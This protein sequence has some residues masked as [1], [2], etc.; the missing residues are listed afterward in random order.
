MSFIELA[1][2]EEHELVPGFRA[3]FVH[4]ER[5]TCAYWDIDAGAALPEHAHPHE[6]VMTLIEGCFE[7]TLAGE[8][9]SL[10]PGSVVTI[11]GMVRHGG[12]ALTKCVAIDI[13]SPVREDYR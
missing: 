12:K 3:R 5:M 6:Q 11:P 13:F 1:D 7:M 4:T 10:S 9:R 8:Q 2:I